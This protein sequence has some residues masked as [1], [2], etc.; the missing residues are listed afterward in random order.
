[1]SNKCPGHL[2]DIRIRMMDSGKM[3]EIKGEEIISELIITD[4]AAYELD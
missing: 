1:M 3:R 2:L 4:E